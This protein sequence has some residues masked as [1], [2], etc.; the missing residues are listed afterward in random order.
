[1][2]VRWYRL[3]KNTLQSMRSKVT[4]SFHTSQF[5]VVLYINCIK[6][7]Q[8]QTKN[9][10]FF[11]LVGLSVPQGSFFSPF[12]SLYFLCFLSQ[13]NQG[14]EFGM[15]IVQCIFSRLLVLFI[16]SESSFQN[17]IMLLVRTQVFLNYMFL[18]PM[19]V[20]QYNR[21]WSFHASK[22]LHVSQLLQ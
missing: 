12:S 4:I 20:S 6:N 7:Q 10:Q 19:V 5:T 18:M 3:L 11:D 9:H 8:I 13:N 15:Y 2:A 16:W 1:M 17:C 22:V 21:L 14:Y